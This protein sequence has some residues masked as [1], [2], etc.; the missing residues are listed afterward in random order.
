[1][2]LRIS[3]LFLSGV[4]FLA[5]CSGSS[6]SSG[7]K[8]PDCQASSTF[9]LT[10]CNL[11]CSITGTCAVTEI[12]QNQ[13][14]VLQFSQNVDPTSVTPSTISIKTE[15]GQCPA[16]DFIVEGRSITFQP[17]VRISGGMISFGFEA[18]RTYILTM[19]GGEQGEQTLRSTSGD[20]LARTVVCAL[21][22]L[23]RRIT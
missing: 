20:P 5:G 10:S 14:I 6:D 19:L 8:T 2:Q 1:M 13:P 21:S 4:I 22:V 18:D 9:C 17:V 7:L 23:T 15:S 3:S 16:G 11:G 12:A